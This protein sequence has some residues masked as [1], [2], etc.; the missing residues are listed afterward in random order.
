MCVSMSCEV[1]AS[2]PDS[3]SIALL[4]A[5][6]RPAQSGMGSSGTEMSG[7]RAFLSAFPKTLFS[8]ALIGGFFFSFAPPRLGGDRLLGKLCMEREVWG[9][10]FRP[11]NPGRPLAAIRGKVQDFLSHF[12]KRHLGLDRANLERHLRHAVDHAAGFI[13]AKCAGTALAHGEQAVARHPCPCR[14]K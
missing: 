2:S 4:W 6:A 9:V 12:G 8:I 11:S 5:R 10:P 7:E 14:S 3:V 13:L 1:R